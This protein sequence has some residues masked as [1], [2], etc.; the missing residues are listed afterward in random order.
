MEASEEGV[1][2]NDRRLVRI[3]SQGRVA[4]VCAGLAAYLDADVSAV[5]LAWVVFS[6]VPGCLIGGALAYLAAWIIMPEGD[7]AA[8]ATPLRSTLKRSRTDRR[9]G[10]VCGGL[11]EYLGIDSTVVR[12]AWAVLT[13]VPGAIVLGLATYLVAWFIIP[14]RTTDV[15]V[16]VPS[17][18]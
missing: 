16:P 14:E 12:V 15:S 3:G 11:A 4:G 2:A 10:G 17:A 6:I 18:I 7:A 9:L 8:A 5:R 13:I 1:M